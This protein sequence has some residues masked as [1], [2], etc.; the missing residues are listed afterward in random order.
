MI[1]QSI[2]Q[3]QLDADKCTHDLETCMFQYGRRMVDIEN[4]QMW[5]CQTVAHST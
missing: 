4:N 1:R 5:L 2:L 3:K